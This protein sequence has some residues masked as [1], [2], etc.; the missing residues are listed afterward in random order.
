MFDIKSQL[1]DAS[2]GV[3]K[4]PVMFESAIQMSSL[5][6]QNMGSR[7]HDQVGRK[8]SYFHSIISPWACCSG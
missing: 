6:A 1:S 7:P 8:F 2:E 5:N 4:Y 3:I